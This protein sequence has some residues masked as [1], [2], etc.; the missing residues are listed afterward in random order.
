MLDVTDSVLEVATIT[1]APG[2]SEEYCGDAILC[3][4][5]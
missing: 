2:E 5:V 3:Y 1:L 4:K